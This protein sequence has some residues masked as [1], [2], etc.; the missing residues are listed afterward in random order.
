MES[1]DTV[2]L[3]GVVRSDT[4][5]PLSMGHVGGCGWSVSWLIE[6]RCVGKKISKR[7]VRNKAES[8]VLD[9]LQACLLFRSTCEGFFV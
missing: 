2:Q 6:R 1:R 3:A 8:A 9:E 5:A 4:V 7:C